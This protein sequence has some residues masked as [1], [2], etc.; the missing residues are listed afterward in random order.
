M[1]TKKIGFVSIM[2]DKIIGTSIENLRREGLKFSVDTLAGQLNISKKTIYKFFP[3]KETLA[4]A[5]YEKYY[6]DARKKVQL[7]LQSNADSLR[8]DLLH[9][10]FDS[11][12]MIRK[13]I[14]NKYKLNGKIYSYTA[15]QNDA[16]WE[17]IAVSWGDSTSERDTGTLRIIIDGAFEKLC[18]SHIDPD[19]V[20][21]RLVQLL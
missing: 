20:I 5:I 21:E 6:S 4:L 9:L 12:I 8:S 14:F 11:K 7:L 2:K 10:Y 1:E 17:M 13:D 19:A 18:D 15:E 3:D 16:L